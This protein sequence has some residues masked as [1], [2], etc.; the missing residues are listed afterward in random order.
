MFIDLFFRGLI[1][2]IFIA[3]SG[4]IGYAVTRLLIYLIPISYF[5]DLLQWTGSVILTALLLMGSAYFYVYR[6]FGAQADLTRRGPSAGGKVALTFDDGPSSGYTPAILKILAEKK[7]YATFFM[8]GSRVEQYPN[9]AAQIVEEGHATGNH[10]YSH[11]TVP[12]APPSML[13]SQIMR[14]NFLLL[15]HTGTYPRYLRPP[16]GLYDARMRRIARLL[17]Q[18]IILWSLSSQDWHRRA[19]ASGIV[20]RILN[21]VTA[22]DIILFH[23]SGSLLGGEGGDRSPTIEALGPIIDGLRAQGLEPVSLEELIVGSANAVDRSA[24]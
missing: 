3:G 14:T 4:V 7:V 17:G 19:T 16:R 13:V 8:V 5:G 18:E 11:I 21:Q 12:N 10:T 22:G 20:R 1:I 24:G 2:L 9:I 15:Q 23:D 6:G